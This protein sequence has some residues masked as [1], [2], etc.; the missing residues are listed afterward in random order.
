ME[1]RGWTIVRDFVGYVATH[2]ANFDGE[3][4]DWQI[5][6]FSVEEVKEEIDEREEA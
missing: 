6:G 3:S 1:Y 2:D 4:R 5:N